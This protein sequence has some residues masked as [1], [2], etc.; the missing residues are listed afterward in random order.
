MLKIGK[1]FMIRD[2]RKDG[3]KQRLPKKQGLIG[4]PFI[5][6]SR[7]TIFQSAKPIRKRK[8]VNSILVKTIFFNEYKKGPQIVSFS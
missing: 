3:H 2:I 8:K 5:S 4:K 6:I 7:R 1:L